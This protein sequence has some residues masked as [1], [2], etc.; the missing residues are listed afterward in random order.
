MMSQTLLKNINTSNTTT[1]SNTSN[2]FLKKRNFNN[3]K[4][5]KCYKKLFEKIKSASK[6]NYYTSQFTKFENN[7]KQTW[8]VIKEKI[9]HNQLT[10]NDDN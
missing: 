4:K 3:E 7:I 1:T 2:L 10:E 8:N 9:T 6:K 5:Y